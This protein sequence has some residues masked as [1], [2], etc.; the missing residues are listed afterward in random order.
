MYVYIHTGACTW[1]YTE[2]QFRYSVT[3]NVINIK[4]KLTYDV[5]VVAR[6]FNMSS[7][8]SVNQWNRG[9]GYLM[10]IKQDSF[11]LDFLIYY[12]G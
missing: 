2:Y 9:I 12:W 1:I 7:W 11:C 3:G 5:T 6:L 4:R 8:K 10:P